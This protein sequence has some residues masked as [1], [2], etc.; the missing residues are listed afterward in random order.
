VFT[1]KKKCAQ[2]VKSGITVL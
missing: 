2:L 1:H